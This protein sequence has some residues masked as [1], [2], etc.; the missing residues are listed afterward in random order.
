MPAPSAIL[1]GLTEIS[2]QWRAVAVGWHVLIGLLVIGLVAGWRPTERLLAVLITLPLVSVSVLAWLAGNA[3]NG[4]VVAGLALLLFRYLPHLR[5]QRVRFDSAWPVLSGA[6]MVAFGWMYPHFLTTDSWTA[7]AYGAPLGV[8]PCA[9]LS[10]A[11]GIASM[12]APLRSG[13]W[14][15]AL[16]SGGLFYGLLGFFYLNVMIDIV[17][18]GGAVALAGSTIWMRLNPRL[19]LK[20]RT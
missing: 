17:L 1:D 2:N 20:L 15:A 18:V 4:V 9:T 12:V 5:P 14:A 11:I 3:F 16:A 8:V 6:T 13:A 7:Y 19:A 10:A